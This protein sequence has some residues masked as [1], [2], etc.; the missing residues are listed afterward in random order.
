MQEL[1]PCHHDNIHCC[2]KIF[3]IKRGDVIYNVRCNAYV[4]HTFMVPVRSTS[5]IVSNVIGSS[6]YGQPAS[7]SA[8]SLPPNAITCVLAVFLMFVLK[9]VFVVERAYI[10]NGNGVW[11]EDRLR[12][13]REIESIRIWAVE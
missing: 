6:S 8:R 11:N 2:I 9:A 13:K 12:T 3:N 4:V 5:P 7:K 10:S 1:I